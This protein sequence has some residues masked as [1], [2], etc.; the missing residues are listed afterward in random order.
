MRNPKFSIMKR[1]KYTREMC[2]TLVRHIVSTKQIRPLEIRS[3]A[4]FI[5]I[6]VTLQA[7]YLL[8]RK[9]LLWIETKFKSRDCNAT[10]ERSSQ[11]CLVFRIEREREKERIY[12][13]CIKLVIKNKCVNM[14][15]WLCVCLY[16]YGCVRQTYRR[17]EEFHDIFA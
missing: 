2:H 13:A 17:E 15:T 9:K 12:Y 1:D 14:C 4:R 8:N 11:A 16:V 5:S 3:T 6:C 7:N 10:F